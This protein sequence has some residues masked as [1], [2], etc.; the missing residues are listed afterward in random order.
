MNLEG[1]QQNVLIVDDEEIISRVL[2]RGFKRQ[3]KDIS[4][5]GVE[6]GSD[7]IRA[8]ESTPYDIVFLDINLGSESING[9]ETL[10]RI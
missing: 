6:H 2:I 9:L 7:A 4:V 8:V 1:R 5:K 10:K 3:F